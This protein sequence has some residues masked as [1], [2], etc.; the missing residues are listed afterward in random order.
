MGRFITERGEG[1]GGGRG[2][3]REG[4][5]IYS[6]ILSPPSKRLINK[7]F[8]RAKNYTVMSHCHITLSRKRNRR[9]EERKGMARRGENKRGVRMVKGGIGRG[10]R[11]GVMVRD[12]RWR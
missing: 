1:G 5:Y 12:G 11:D 3:E 7:I 8:S 2:R 4:Y 6:F 9:T 10:G